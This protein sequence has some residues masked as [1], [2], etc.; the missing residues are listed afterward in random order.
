MCWPKAAEIVFGG[1]AVYIWMMLPIFYMFYTFFNV[2]FV[3]N[4]KRFAYFTDP[5]VGIHGME[6]NP[7]VVFIVFYGIDSLITITKIVL[8]KIIILVFQ[9]HVSLHT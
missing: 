3:Y 1:K 6:G 5:F 4:T 9:A 2:P 7:E 8:S